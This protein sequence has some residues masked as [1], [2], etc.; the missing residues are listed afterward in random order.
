MRTLIINANVITGDGTT[1]LEECSLAIEGEL[2]HKV[3]QARAPVLD[4]GDRIIDANGGFVIPGIINHHTHGISLGPSLTCSADLPLPKSRV[5]QNLN[6]HL[7]QGETTIVNLDG[8]ATMDEVAQVRVLSPMLVQTMSTHTPLY[9][10][11]AKTI[12]YGGLKKEHYSITAEDVI[13]QGALGIGEGS[14]TSDMSYCDLMYFPK[15]VKDKT[16]VQISMQDSEDIRSALFTDPPDEKTFADIMN[17]M[18]I[19]SA[20]EDVKAMA[21]ETKRRAKLS[22]EANQEAACIAVKLGVPFLMHNSPDTKPEVLDLVQN[23][24]DLMIACHCNYRYKP[25]EACEVARIVKKAGGWVD[26]HSGDFFNIQQFFRNHATTL[27]LLEEGLVD[28]ISTD[29]IGGYWDSILRFLEYSVAQ[30]VIDLP[31]AIAL[32]TRNVTA[33]IPNIAPNRGEI[34][35]GK[36]ADLVILSPKSISEVTTVIIGGKVVVDEGR[37]FV[38]TDKFGDDL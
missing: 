29:Y 36:V 24:N 30:H 20:M 5:M 16:G 1:L 23:L 2:I 9:L 33:A 21:V 25:Q 28:I 13:K 27:A 22:I 14:G 18:G 7:L 35:E 37:I 38:P 6:R 4:R 26:I 34:A 3:N 32:A 19:S 31:Q 10:K 12:D 17:N 11:L 8:F 15:V